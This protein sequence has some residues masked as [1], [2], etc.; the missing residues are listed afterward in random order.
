MKHEIH[1]ALEVLLLF[2]GIFLGIFGLC[3]GNAVVG[4][5]LVAWGVI[6]LILAPFVSIVRHV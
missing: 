5:S 1:F 3:V 4:A 6:F 2:S